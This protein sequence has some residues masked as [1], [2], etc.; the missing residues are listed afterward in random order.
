[1]PG[2][3]GFEGKATPK[4]DGG[5][6]VGRERGPAGLPRAWAS[7]QT[8]AAR[9]AAP[10]V[11]SSRSTEGS[12]AAGVPGRRGSEGVVLAVITEGPISGPGIVRVAGIPRS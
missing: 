8:T 10:P 11:T 2:R 1:M 9:A 4:A 3:R 6:R 5:V 7:V 12:G